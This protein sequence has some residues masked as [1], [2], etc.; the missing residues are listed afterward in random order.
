MSDRAQLHGAIY[1]LRF[2]DI[3]ALAKRLK[4]DGLGFDANRKFAAMKNERGG[5][6]KTHFAD[7]LLDNCGHDDIG[8]AL[9][10]KSLAAVVATLAPAPVER[11]ANTPT[12]G[13]IVS[14]IR[15][16]RTPEGWALGVDYRARKGKVC[17]KCASAVVSCDPG[18]LTY[19]ARLT[20]LHVPAWCN[21]C[22]S[23]WRMVF[24]LTGYERV[25]GD[26][27]PAVGFDGNDRENQDETTVDH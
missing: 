6:M 22:E 17:P 8:A 1:A 23:Q 16:V 12:V 24:N 21:T 14:A 10:N 18:A 2:N 11:I 9:T 27:T 15:P 3:L 5:D 26:E 4:P 7:W 25:S 20:M 13:A 19:D